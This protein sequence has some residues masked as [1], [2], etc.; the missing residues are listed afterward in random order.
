MEKVQ[1]CIFKKTFNYPV[2]IGSKILKQIGEFVDIDRYSSVNLISDN[3]VYGL[4]GKN[5]SI[6]KANVFTFS[7]GE[8]S[9]NL[10]TVKGAYEFLAEKNVDRHGLIINMGGGV[11]ADLGGFVAST[12]LRGI[13]FINIPTTVEAMVDASFGG[14]NGV[15]LG[16][17]KNYVGT[18]NQPKAVVADIDTLKTMPKRSFIQGFAEVIKHG[19]IQDKFYFFRVT[20]KRP[21]QFSQ[22]ELVEIIAESVRIKGEIVQQDERE[23][24]L[25]KLLNFGHTVGHAIESQ[26]F[27]SKNPL[28]HGEAVAIGMVA[29]AKISADLGMINEKDFKIIERAI[30]DFGLPTRYESGVSVDEVVTL[31]EKDKKSQHGKIKWTLLSA[32]GV[33]DYNIQF[34]DK[35]VREGIQYV[36]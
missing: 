1:I 21:N 23:T 10:Q 30:A 27:K 34:D 13:D 6:K 35:F 28:F 31:L 16:H 4:H 12:Y 32:I 18:F 7:S 15:N 3:T 8:S 5:L 11:V 26:S 25:R 36:L 20:K 9:K 2:F 17:Y 24:G 29:E 14:K 22:K 33:G 19:L